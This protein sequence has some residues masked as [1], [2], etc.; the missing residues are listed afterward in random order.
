MKDIGNIEKRIDR[1]E[2]YLALSLM[3]M[4]AKDKQILDANGNDRFKNGI[5][6]NPFDSDLLSDLADPSYNAAYNSVA[7]EC[8]PNYDESDISLI[9]SWT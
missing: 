8:E 4:A 7:K 9:L 3:E 6:V 2:Y 1:L 5:Y